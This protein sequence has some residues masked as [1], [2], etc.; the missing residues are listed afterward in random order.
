MELVRGLGSK[1]KRRGKISGACCHF[2]LV[3]AGCR[4]EAV[5]RRGP[6]RWQRRPLLSEGRSAAQQGRAA[7]LKAILT[8]NMFLAWGFK[9]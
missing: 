5:V 7:A 9:P 8:K 4:G 1:G 6:W 2:W 3:W